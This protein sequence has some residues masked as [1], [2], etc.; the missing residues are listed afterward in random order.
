MLLLV[1]GLLAAQALQPAKEGQDK[2]AG[3]GD[4]KIFFSPEAANPTIRT[5]DLG[6][7]PNLAQQ[8]YLYIRN[9]GPKETAAPVTVELRAGGKAIATWTSKQ[10]IPKESEAVKVSFSEKPPQPGEKPPELAPVAG[11]LEAVVLVGGAESDRAPVHFARPDEFVAIKSFQFD[12]ATNIL[13]AQLEANPQRPFIGPPARVELVLRSDR[14]PALVPGQKKVG[15]YAGSLSA[16]EPV[17]LFA[18]RLQFRPGADRNGLVYLT[19]D[20]YQR[21]FTF[22]A[23]FSAEGRSDLVRITQ[24]ILRLETT[25]LAKAGGPSQVGLEMDNTASSTAQLGLYRDSSSNADL[26]G[27]LELYPS[28][29]DIRILVSPLGPNGAILFRTEVSDWQ[30]KLQTADIFGDRVLRLEL[31]NKSKDREDFIDSGKPIKLDSQG[32]YETTK[33]IV[34]GLRIDGS[35][36][37]DVDFLDFPKQIVRGADL[38]VKATGVD[39]ESGIAKVVFFLGKEQDDGKIPPTAPK[40]ELKPASKDQKEFEAKLQAPTD[41][42]G[43]FDVSVAFINGVGMQTIRTVQIELIDAKAGGGGATIT[44]KVVFGDNAI[45]GQ[46]VL[47]RDPQGNVKDTTKAGTEG[48]AR[49]VFTFKNVAPG[50]YQLVAI[51][52]ALRASGQAAV[53][54]GAGEDKKLTEPITLRR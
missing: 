50:T 18:S 31:I 2:K 17:K 29:R 25:G 34:R 11:P 39:P 40:V 4:L 21:A 28:E 16:K 32:N 51:N 33:E 37:E 48:A 53:Q 3:G 22:R 23:T 41:K 35:P 6:L 12:G 10:A 54:V 13:V 42:K 5:S 45:P 8:V 19:V 26:E 38:P 7:R 9:S 14:I 46:E 36:P 52:G 49:G 24:P 27:P 47:L 1:G 20:G 15:S 43:T 44:G 30:S